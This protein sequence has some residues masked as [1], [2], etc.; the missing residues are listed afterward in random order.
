MNL[1]TL[2][3]KPIQKSELTQVL[4]L[5]QSC[6]GGLWSLE[7]YQREIDSPNSSLLALW[8]YSEESEIMVGF[9]CFWAILEEAHITILAVHQDYQGRGLG[10]F[11]FFSLLEDAIERKLERATLE[12]K[13]SNQVALSLYKKF[14]FQVAGRRKGYYQKT[15]EDALILWKNGLQTTEFTQNLAIWRGEI[16]QQLQRENFRLNH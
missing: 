8:L 5:D 7:A 13:L 12:V 10:K 3:L 14:G 2:Q 15:G 4:A 9:G 6:L 16:W 11:L 1:S